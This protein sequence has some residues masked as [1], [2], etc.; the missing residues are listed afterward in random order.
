[1]VGAL[2]DFCPFIMVKLAGITNFND[3]AA[4]KKKPKNFKEI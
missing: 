3:E 2:H 1:M 4:A